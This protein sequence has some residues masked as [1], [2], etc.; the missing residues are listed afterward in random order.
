M[1]K[2]KYNFNP[3]V[4]EILNELNVSSLSEMN[5]VI[6]EL[7]KG[8]IEKV[9]EEELTDHLGYEKW[10]QNSRKFYWENPIEINN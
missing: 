2:K 8:L 4:L 10:D 5:E 9:L 1:A 7:K 3:K 6:N